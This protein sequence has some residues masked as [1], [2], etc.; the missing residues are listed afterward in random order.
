[1][2]RRQ[3]PRPRGRRPRDLHG[4][5]RYG[6]AQQQ[7]VEAGQGPRPVLLLHRRHDGVRQPHS[8]RVLVPGEAPSRVYIEL[9]ILLCIVHCIV[10]RLTL[11]TLCCTVYTPTAV[12]VHMYY[13]PFTL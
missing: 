7:C 9:Y 11:Y 3:P 4:G 6:R 5:T 13:S 2:Q 8:W 1:V 12:H 10:C